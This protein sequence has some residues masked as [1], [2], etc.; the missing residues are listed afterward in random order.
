MAKTRSFFL[1]ASCTGL[2]FA[3]GVQIYH[4][5]DALVHKIM[6]FDRADRTAVPLTE[7]LRCVPETAMI[8]EVYSAYTILLWKGRL[9]IFLP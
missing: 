7:P 5:P 8:S 3:K 1:E 2:I 9:L 4:I 6:T